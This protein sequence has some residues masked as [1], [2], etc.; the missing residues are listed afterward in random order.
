MPTSPFIRPL[1]SNLRAD[2]KVG[3]TSSDASRSHTFSAHYLTPPSTH[4]NVGDQ[5]GHADLY[6]R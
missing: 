1:F 4:S 2:E 6:K 5:T 3:C